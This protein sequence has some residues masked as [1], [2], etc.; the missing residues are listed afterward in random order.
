MECYLVEY[1]VDL[2]KILSETKRPDLSSNE[3]NTSNYSDNPSA[4]HQFV[5]KIAKE[6]LKNEF[7]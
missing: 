3:G 6:P 5:E 1:M 7:I 4:K 2:D